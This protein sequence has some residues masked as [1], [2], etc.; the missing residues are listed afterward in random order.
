MSEEGESIEST[1]SSKALE[2]EK[3]NSFMEFKLSFI[4]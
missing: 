3:E 4:T 1:V 2:E